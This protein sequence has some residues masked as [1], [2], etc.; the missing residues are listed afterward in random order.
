MYWIFTTPRSGSN[1]LADRLAA[2]GGVEQAQ[3]YFDPTIVNCLEPKSGFSLDD[4]ESDV[5]A[6]LEFLEGRFSRGNEFGVK[7]L[8]PH[9]QSLFGMRNL[10]QA[11]HQGRHIYLSR[12]DTVAQAVSYYIALKTDQWSSRSKGPTKISL[13]DLAYDFDEIEILFKRTNAQNA[14]IKNFL[15][16]N[17]VDFVSVVYEELL[18][19][20]E[21]A[22]RRIV[23]FLNWETYFSTLVTRP[24]IFEIQSTDVNRNFANRF[25]ADMM[26]TYFGV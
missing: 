5:A 19:D 12:R 7:L 11:I 21:A 15:Q 14:H 24:S 3:E 25:K 2:I 26:E 23:D 4:P 10:R 1:L 16:I 13:E 22:L 6:Y 9:I 17:G 8:Y 18:D 20:Q